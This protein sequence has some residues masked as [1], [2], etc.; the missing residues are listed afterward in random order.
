MTKLKQPKSKSPN[1]FQ[2][3]ADQLGPLVF[4]GLVKR[5]YTNRNTYENVMSQLAWESSYGTSDVARNNHNYGGYGHDGHGNYTVFKNDRDFV[6]AYLNT[7]SSRYKKALQSN[8]VYSFARHL[9]NKGYYE[10]SYEN[11]SSNLANMKTLKRYTGRHYHITQKPFKKNI[12]PVVPNVLDKTPVQQT[13]QDNMVAP[14]KQ[15]YIK[16]VVNNVQQPYVYDQ[17]IAQPQEVINKNY[18]TNSKMFSLPPIEQTM[19]AIMNG[20]P[21]LQPGFANGKDYNPYYNYIIQLA[22]QKPL[23]WYR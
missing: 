12:V 7:M 11:Y 16:P 18:V 20:Q 19:N 1:Q 6:N 17:P 5:G 3:F 8:D 15:T 13:V 14:F 2:A 9:K 10:D 23:N 22:K 21:L 4:E